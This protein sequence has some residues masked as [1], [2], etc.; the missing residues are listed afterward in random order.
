MLDAQ[1]KTH[2]Y[3]GCRDSI[4][5][6]GGKSKMIPRFWSKFKYIVINGELI[7]IMEVKDGMLHKS[8]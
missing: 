2:G 7:K 4:K 5:K 6:D 8:L 1:K 3:E